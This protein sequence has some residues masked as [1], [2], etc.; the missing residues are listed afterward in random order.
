MRPI[1]QPRNPGR[2]LCDTGCIKVSAQNRHKWLTKPATASPRKTLKSNYE[3]TRPQVP[4]VAIWRKCGT[5]L[6]VPLSR[7]IYEQTALDTAHR[8]HRPVHGEHG[9]DGHCDIVA[10]DCRR[11]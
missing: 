6:C 10:R 8:R 3:L 11:H 2:E 7:K 5:H 1:A 9:F 4:R